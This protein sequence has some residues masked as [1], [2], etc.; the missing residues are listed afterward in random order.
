[1]ARPEAVALALL[2]FY[3]VQRPGRMFWAGLALGVAVGS[4]ALFAPL[5]PLFAIWLMFPADGRW[6]RA[7]L[8]VA[9]AAVALVP[10]AVIAAISPDRFILSA[11]ELHAARTPSPEVGPLQRF[12][13]LYSLVA[14]PQS[15]VVLGLAAFGL[16]RERTRV[17]ALALGC[18]AVL[19][20]VSML[21]SPAFEQYM[22]CVLPFLLLVGAPALEV[23]RVPAFL[24]FVLYALA[25]R[26]EYVNNVR[27]HSHEGDRL[28]EVERVVTALKSH[29]VPGETILAFWPGYATLSGTRLPDGLEGPLSPWIVDRL[30]PEQKSTLNVPTLA[31]IERWIRE[32]KFRIV[33]IGSHR[34]TFEQS[35]AMRAWARASGYREVSSGR[36]RE[37]YVR[38]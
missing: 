18:A 37:V 12:Q 34:F 4:R 6:K 9:G 22:V 32:R 3:L 36:G 21:P 27:S 5:V 25:G 11:F 8:F 28:E 33:V 17:T 14:R 10:F 13:M 16:W 31:D 23:P 7:G 24:V 30:T 38:E 29:A 2:A 19:G 15:I 26:Q 20:I 35:A 1:M